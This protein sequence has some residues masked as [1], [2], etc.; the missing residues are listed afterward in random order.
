MSTELHID[1][2]WPDASVYRRGW[3]KATARPW[4]DVTGDGTI[5]LERGRAEFLRLVSADVA[6]RV[7]GTVYSPALFGSA[8]RVWRRAGYESHLEMDV[9]ERP[10]RG[11]LFEP[12]SGTTLE[13]TPDI[14]EL[15]RVDRQ[16]F[17]GF[18][19]MSEL[20][21]AEAMSATPVSVAILRRDGEDLVGYALVGAQATVSFLQRI[22]V[23]PQ[24]EGSGVGSA[25]LEASID[26]ARAR[27]TR[28]MVLNVRP[29]DSRARSF[30]E[31][32]GFKP[33]G[34]KLQIL[35]FTT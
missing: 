17:E 19:G 5:R 8:T 20:G 32:N 34:T 30:Y 13:D 2:S 33:T 1:G 12:T 24:A 22:G 15:L 21:L 14:E 31:R 23:V 18:W 27:G 25:L 26:W 16:A 11:L 3:A 9:L 6:G 4:N 7:Q 28:S 35:R 29:G 10:L